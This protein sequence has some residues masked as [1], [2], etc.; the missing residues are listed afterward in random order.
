MIDGP[1]G[2]AAGTVAPGRG[3]GGSVPYM[4]SAVLALMNTLGAAPA[5]GQAMIVP[6]VP[7][8]VWPKGPVLIEPSAAADGAVI[9]TAGA[10]VAG[11]VVRT[12]GAAR[13]RESN[14]RKG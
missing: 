8:D 6:T 13:G 5:V 7:R 3:V 14:L 12:A 10:D 4:G 11:D 9:G 1:N 2:G